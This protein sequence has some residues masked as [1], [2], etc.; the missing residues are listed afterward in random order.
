M[1]ANAV[2]NTCSLKYAV[3][4]DPP[5]EP[6]IPAEPIATPIRQRTRPLL[7]WANIP[8]ML[9]DRTMMRDPVVASIGLW[10]RR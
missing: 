7:A 4:N 10:P 1:T 6:R 9:V 2:S 5:T 8:A 3:N